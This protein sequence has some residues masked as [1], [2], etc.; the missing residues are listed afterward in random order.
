M[1]KESERVMLPGELEARLLVTSKPWYKAYVFA[2]KAMRDK[3]HITHPCML[4]ILNLWN[5]TMWS[6]FN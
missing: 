6:V 2:T 1:E 4:Q 5:T 3:L